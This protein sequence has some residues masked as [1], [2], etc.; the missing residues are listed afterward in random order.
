MNVIENISFRNAFVL[1]VLLAAG[2]VY[3]SDAE[4]KTNPLS[5]PDENIPRPLANPSIPPSGFP[6]PFQTIS[7]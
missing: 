1:F 3:F 7:I 6:E 4:R 2:M 5:N